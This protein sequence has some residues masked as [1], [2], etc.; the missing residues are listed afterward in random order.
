MDNFIFSLNTTIP[1]FGVIALGYILRRRKTVDESF[2]NTANKL[3]FH[4][5]LPAML[6]RDISASGIAGNF[7]VGEGEFRGGNCMWNQLY[8]I[9]EAIKAF[10]T[11]FKS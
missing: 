10:E 7:D 4:Y 9:I 8:P 3:A 1:V 6:F 11:S 5:F 2:V